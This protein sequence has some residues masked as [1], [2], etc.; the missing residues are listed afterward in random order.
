AQKGTFFDNSFEG[1]EA[2]QI[3]ISSLYRYYRSENEKIF[4]FLNYQLRVVSARQEE[5]TRDTYP[6]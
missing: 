5:K 4:I 2:S 3:H 6:D 1:D